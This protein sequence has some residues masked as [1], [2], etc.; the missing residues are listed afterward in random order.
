MTCPRNSQFDHD[1]DDYSESD[2][3]LVVAII[4][5][6]PFQKLQLLFKRRL[7][8]ETFGECKVYVSWRV[9]SHEKVPFL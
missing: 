1:I 9:T 5:K 4:A 8:W 3:R 7:N 6:H 2:V